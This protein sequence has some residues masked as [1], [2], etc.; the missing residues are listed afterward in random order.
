MKEETDRNKYRELSIAEI[1]KFI[2]LMSKKKFN[3]LNYVKTEGDWWDLTNFVAQFYGAQH[4]R[5]LWL[6]LAKRNEQTK[7]YLGADYGEDALVNALGHTFFSD[8]ESSS[9]G[10]GWRRHWPQGKRQSF[11]YKFNR[12]TAA[13]HRF[14]NSELRNPAN[15][16]GYIGYGTRVR[17]NFNITSMFVS[18]FRSYG[19]LDNGYLGVADGLE[20]EEAKVQFKMFVYPLIGISPDHNEYERIEINWVGFVSQS[21]KF[22]AYVVLN[23]ELIEKRT[24]NN[25]KHA[26]SIQDIEKRVAMNE[27]IIDTARTNLLSN[28]S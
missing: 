18:Q 9:T 13:M 25:C 1:T 20:L 22:D 24:E 21:Q 2:R 6:K 12:I 26:K 27:R 5:T 14:Y 4:A 17:T 8:V 11:T 23:G 7:E 19:S 3:Y 16:Y 15:D 28:M 10:Y